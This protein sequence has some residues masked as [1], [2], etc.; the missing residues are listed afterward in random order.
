M[1]NALFL[2]LFFYKKSQGV[3]ICYDATR[4]VYREGSVGRMTGYQQYRRYG[5]TSMSW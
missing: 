5:M 1:H 2:L 3:Y 4:C